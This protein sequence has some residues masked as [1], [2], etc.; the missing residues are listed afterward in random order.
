MN[1][2]ERRKQTKR[3]QI[4]RASLSLF[5]QYGVQKVNIQEIAKKANVSQ[6]TIYNYFGSKDELVIDVVKSLL[7]DQF[8]EYIKIKEMD[9]PFIEKV[10]QIIAKKVQFMKQFSNEFLEVLLEDQGEIKELLHSYNNEKALPFFREFIE[11]G[12]QNGVI[13]ESLSSETILFYVNLVSRE[14]QKHPEFLLSDEVRMN[15]FTKDILHLVFY[16]IVGKK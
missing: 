6:V 13:D 14:I 10:E 12:K 16:G 4:K 2:F 5:S 15:E 11:D 7:E 1:G 9:V 8:N 3:D